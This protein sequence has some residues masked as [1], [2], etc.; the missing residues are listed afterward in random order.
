MGPP[1]P[2]PRLARDGSHSTHPLGGVA[3]ITRQDVSPPLH[4]EHAIPCP[5]CKAEPGQRCT[6]QRGRRISIPSRDARIT[7]WNNRPPD[8]PPSNPPPNRSTPT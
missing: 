5:W 2:P 4:P 7:A 3:L 1:Q 8:P 6:G